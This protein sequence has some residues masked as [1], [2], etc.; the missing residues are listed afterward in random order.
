MILDGT[1]VRDEILARLK[2]RV[3]R[4][5][6]KP[7]LVVIRVGDDPASAI[8]VRNKIKACQQLGMVSEELTPPAATTT[9]E[10]LALI[11]ELNHRPDID[12][13]LVQTPLP[14]HIDFQAV[15]QSIDPGKDVDAF[16]PQNVGH[17]VAGRSAPRP[18]TPAGIMELL[19]RYEIPVAGKKAV[20]I[21]RSDIVGKPMALMLLAAD[22]TVTVAHSKTINLAE[23]C[24]RA[25]LL[26][27]AIGKAAFVTA[28]FLKPG[29]VVIDVGMN[30]VT[31]R[32]LAERLGRLEVFN[33]RGDT[34]VG[35]VHPLD[36]Q[37]VASAYTP[38]PGG[39]GPLTIAMLMENTVTLAEKH[40]C[41]G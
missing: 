17:L 15:L 37:K 33:R 32:D 11:Q 14:K 4:L 41:S 36:V 30:R 9:A 8:Y 19:R 1:V 2:P 5:P 20:V 13:I 35:D 24:R 6:R 38:V 27:A 16:H 3:E 18:C 39:V 26:V 25:D 10:L 28:E 29:A 40:Q 7:G 21:G 23:E 22:A 34:V 12:G 31:D